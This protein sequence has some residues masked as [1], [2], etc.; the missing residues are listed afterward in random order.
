MQVQ[1]EHGVR[2]E[3]RSRQPGSFWHFIIGSQHCSSRH[4]LHPVEV[5][6]EQLG[7]CNSGLFEPASAPD[8]HA[9]HVATADDRQLSTAFQ[10]FVAALLLGAHEAAQAESTF[11]CADGGQ[12]SK[13]LVLVAH[14]GSPRQSPCCVAHC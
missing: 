14:S 12:A 5:D 4:A 9:E 10:S 13:Q 2:Q 3:L 8:P 1:S 7:S 11:P 6:G